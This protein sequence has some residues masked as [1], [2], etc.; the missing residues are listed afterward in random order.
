MVGIEAAVAE[1]GDLR[2]LSGGRLVKQAPSPV[3][4]R[5][6]CLTSVHSARR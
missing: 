1:R 4:R 5:N 2:V 3:P 6:F